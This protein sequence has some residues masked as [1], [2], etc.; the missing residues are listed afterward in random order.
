MFFVNV[1]SLFSDIFRYFQTYLAS[2]NSISGKKEGANHVSFY[3]FHKKIIFISNL[4]FIGY[5]FV[6]NFKH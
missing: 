4:F 6:C 3:F 2:N 1:F 5:D